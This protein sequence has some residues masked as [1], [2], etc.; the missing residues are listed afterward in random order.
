MSNFY[1][2]VNIKSIS[3]FIL[4]IIT[5]TACSKQDPTKFKPSQLNGTWT[6]SENQ[7]ALVINTTKD[8]FQYGDM[9][10]VDMPSDFS[11]IKDDD[12]TNYTFSFS[13]T[14]TD[15][16]GIA[17]GVALIKKYNVKV[18]FTSDSECEV[19][20]ERYF[21]ETF[22]KTSSQA[23]TTFEVS[24]LAGLSG[25]KWKS[26]DGTGI[27]FNISTEGKISGDGSSSSDVFIGKDIPN[28]KTT[29][30]KVAQF[31]FEI[32]HQQKTYKFRFISSTK[33]YV[34]DK[35]YYRQ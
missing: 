9:S 5:I 30:G 26:A 7:N 2:G 33:G 12:T 29:T 23:E 24:D 27:V 8:T 15:P 6:G 28:W 14:I 11:S 16:N 1:Q 18:S 17:Q 34:N 10:C 4:T 25:A 31:E 20:D 19:S 22:N 32:T 21:A 13:Y 3:L 35:L